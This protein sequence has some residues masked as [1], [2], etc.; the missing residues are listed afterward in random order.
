MLQN[1]P[2]EGAQ[3]Y[4]DALLRVLAQGLAH[5]PIIHHSGALE[6]SFDENW[7]LALMDA[8]SRDD[9][10]ST[11][12]LLRARLPLHL[13]RHVGWLTAQMMQRLNSAKPD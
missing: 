10:A 3:P 9:H 8:I 11:A 5:G 13:R 2:Y 1:A 12:F 4:A 7:L 6:C